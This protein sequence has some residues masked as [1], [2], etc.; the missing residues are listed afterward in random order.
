MQR[1]G[2]AGN[3][4]R[5][6]AGIDLVACIGAGAGE[7]QRSGVAGAVAQRA[8]VQ[9]NAA[10]GDADAAGVR[11]AGLNG[12]VEHQR[13]AAAAR[14]ITRRHG[15]ATDAQAQCRRAANE[16]GL[17]HVHGDADHVA[18]VEQA[19]LDAAGRRDGNAADAGRHAVVEDQIGWVVGHRKVR[20]VGGVALCIGQRAAI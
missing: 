8:A 20:Q 5:R 14:N 4:E 11:L 7:A 2:I 9:G 16:G 18:G 17:T 10:A 13:V 15:C 19:A 6:P 12:V 1:A 3:G